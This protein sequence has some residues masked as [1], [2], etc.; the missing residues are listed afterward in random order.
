MLYRALAQSHG[1]LGS[2]VNNKILKALPNCVAGSGV[3]GGAM[4]DVMI[5]VTRLDSAK[6]IGMAL[7]SARRQHEMSLADVSRRLNISSDFLASLEAGTFDHLPGPTYVVGFLRSYARLVGIDSDA[8]VD[9]YRG[10]EGQAPLVQ[11][12][13]MPMT[14]RPPQRSG[15]LVASVVVVLAVLAYSGWYWVNGTAQNDVLT[16]DLATPE[17]TAPMTVGAD[18]PDL[19]LTLPDTTTPSPTAPSPT[20]PTTVSA[21]TGA[22]GSTDAP[23]PVDVAVVPPQMPVPV[24]EMVPAKPATTSDALA[25]STAPVLESQQTSLPTNAAQATLRDPGQE[26]IIR[27]VASSWVEIIR[28]DGGAVMTKLMRAGDSYVVDAD[29]SVYLS[30]GNAGGLVVIVGDDKPRSVGK[31]GEIVRDLPL[32]AETLRETL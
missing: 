24:Q 29:S 26:I 16:T 22:S 19:A 23:A 15:P 10:L 27:A 5:D 32:T 7:K 3:V 18:L 1:V 30:T 28:N 4:Q 13:N 9:S 20:A 17:V 14:A 25:T 8:L 2:P 12:Y 31:I 21:V 11:T 6:K